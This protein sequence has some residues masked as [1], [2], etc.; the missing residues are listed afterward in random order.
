MRPQHTIDADQS[1]L[2]LAGVD[3]DR[4]AEIALDA[5]RAQRRRW[6]LLNRRPSALRP[7]EALEAL[8]HEALVVM[9]VNPADLDDRRRLVLACQRIHAIASEV[10]GNE[11]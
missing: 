5:I 1:V 9:V 11:R 4:R 7:R 3:V 6:S 8:L 2:D 10:V